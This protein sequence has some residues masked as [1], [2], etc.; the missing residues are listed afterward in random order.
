[1]Q[2]AVKC[3]IIKIKPLKNGII[4]RQRRS[5]DGF[6]SLKIRIVRV[7]VF[8][9]ILIG[10]ILQHQ[11]FDNRKEL[12]VDFPHGRYMLFWRRLQNL[13]FGLAGTQI[14]LFFFGQVLVAGNQFSN[15]IRSFCP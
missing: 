9:G 1:M 13:F 7:G 2:S 6:V 4:D 3:R 10:H 8:A 12:C 5:F 15:A 11:L 14:S